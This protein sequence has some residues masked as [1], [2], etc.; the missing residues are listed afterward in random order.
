MTQHIILAGDTQRA[1]AR[2]VIT[3]AQQYSI[4]TVKGP[5]RSTRQNALLWQALTAI[6]R[7]KPDGREHTPE[8]W[9]ELFLHACG[10]AVQFEMGLNGQPFPTGFR[11][12]QLT[13]SQFSEL[14][15][16]IFAWCAEKG[17]PTD[18]CGVINA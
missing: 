4:V 7:A 3:D 10:H 16:F 12:S 2:Q 13:K 11:S 14:I 5:T 1:W 8:V 9:K 6:S 17:V 15:E 18:P